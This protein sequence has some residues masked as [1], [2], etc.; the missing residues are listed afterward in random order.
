MRTMLISLLIGLLTFQAALIMAQDKVAQPPLALSLREAV[1]MALSPE[2]NV[3]IA[4]AGQSERAAEARFRQ[5]RAAVLPDVETSITGQNQ[6]LNLSALGFASV[7]LPVTGFSFPR[8]VGP[9][10]TVDARVHVKQNLIDLAASRRSQALRAGIETARMETDA[11]RDQVT[12][13][14]AKLYFSAVHAVDSVK[15]AQAMLASAESALRDLMDRQAEGKALTIDVSH[16]RVRLAVERQ[17]LMQAQLERS[18]AAFDLLGALNR[19]LNTPLNL[20][21]SLEFAPR[22]TWTTA[23]ALV[24][25]MASRSDIVSQR[26][27]VKAIRLNDRSIQA[28]RLPS[29]A[30][31]ADVGSMG[32]TIANSIGTYDVGVSLSIPVFDGGRRNSRREETSALVRQEELRAGQLEKQ[33]ELEVREALLKLDMARGQV[34]L[35]AEEVAV[36][37]EEFAHRRRRYEQGVTGQSEVT[38]AQVKMAQA[39]DERMTAL[40]AWNEARI[41]LM[42]A[43]GTVRTLAQ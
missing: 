4:V 8:S 1:R 25:A 34:E 35:S 5:S 32:T 28:E 10:D 7:H 18:L 27:R 21:D 29:L 22:E 31:Y 26:Q 23:Q 3:A 43:M 41:D 11:V 12:G 39:A 15:A 42:Q 38:E 13:Q 14:V 33:V 40:Y 30:G 36:A 24:I 6:V 16:A 19:D 9:F 17:R 37:T 2:G 20:T